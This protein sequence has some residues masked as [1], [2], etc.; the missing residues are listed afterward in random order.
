M[1][2]LRN[3]SSHQILTSN[4]INEVKRKINKTASALSKKVSSSFPIE[5][6]DLNRKSILIDAATTM[7][8]IAK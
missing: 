5:T 1:S 2:M 6:N 8:S 3:N 7:L 4:Q